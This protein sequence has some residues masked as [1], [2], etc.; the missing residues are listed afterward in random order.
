MN[1]LP[2]ASNSANLLFSNTSWSLTAEGMARAS[3]LI[4]LIA[5]SFYLNTA[6]YGTA[7]LALACHEI[8]RVFTRIGCGAKIIQCAEQDLEGYASNAITLQW[9]MCISL[10]VCQLLVAELIA[11][12]YQNPALTELIKIM[13]LAH[14]YYPIVTIKV[15]LLQRENR[16]RYFSLASG[17]CVV[18]ENLST[19]LL[20]F[21]GIGI[22]AVALAKVIAA[23]LWVALFSLP[24]VRSI[25]AGFDRQ[26]MK[27]LTYYSGKIL[28]TEVTKTFR[29][30]SD[31]LL[32]G[33]LLDGELFGLYSFARSAGL[34]LSQSLSAAFVGGLYPYLC[35]QMR[36]KNV[37]QGLKNTYIACAC[38]SVIFLAQA[39]LAPLYIDWFFPDR[40]SEATLLVCIL[41]SSA[42][43]L[44]IVDTHCVYLR[45][46]NRPT[47]ELFIALAI[48]S[49]TFLGLYFWSP[50]TPM[51]FAIALCVI[52]YLYLPI[53]FV[54]SKLKAI[55]TKYNMF[56][57]S[58]NTA[59]E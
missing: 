35:Q 36:I 2:K 44:L 14:L 1:L 3:R 21:L 10:T 28:S 19:A 30:Q 58:L 4:T 53:L 46:Q 17:S 12:F 42:I 25:R 6:D 27:S 23:I 33:K 56:F 34:G 31:M 47:R 41:C 57:P 11:T 50:N 54:I 29:Q 48:G 20:V 15:Y 16:M 37:T 45:A 13:A 22:Y 43:P 52:S 55:P 38:V 40:W 32:A 59:G 7:M 18:A 39:A 51:N 9:V 26:I 24:K 49:F 5:L 8:L